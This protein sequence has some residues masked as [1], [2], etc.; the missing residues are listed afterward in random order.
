MAEPT[1]EQA[2]MEAEQIE[3]KKAK[4]LAVI[5]PVAMLIVAVAGWFLLGTMWNY[6][7][8]SQMETRISRAHTFANVV[9]EWTDRGKEI[10]SGIWRVQVSEDPFEKFVMYY[11]GD[12]KGHWFGLALDED[13][14]IRYTLY[15]EK[16]IPEEYLTN[17]PDY[18]EQY[19]LLT[20]HFFFKKKKTVAVWTPEDDWMHGAAD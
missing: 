2:I 12:A 10:E 11:F 3:K 8:H 16:E 7:A 9:H 6:T 17:P 13:G 19:A 4:K 15:S 14:N 20:S 18:E 1:L 5:L